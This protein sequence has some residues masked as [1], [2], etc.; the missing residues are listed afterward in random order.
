ML[1]EFKDGI[2]AYL[3]AAGIKPKSLADLIAWNQDHSDTVM[4]WFG[5][6]L[7]EMAQAKGSLKDAAYR[8]ARAKAR[9]IAGDDGL[10]ATLDANRVDVLM[11]PSAGPSWLT[12]LLLG[13]HYVGGGGAGMAAV[14]GTPSIT[15]PMGE[16]HGL[17]L[18]LALMGPAYSEAQL[19]GLAYA[20]EQASLAR[21]PPKYFATLPT[22]TAAVKADDA[23]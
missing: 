22:T 4:P 6:E 14:A 8:E 9:K 1:Y 19:I 10:F 23:H 12:D 2:N 15:V 11:V 13:D 18:G 16:S 5:Q 17:P 20:F 21:T 7:F 3:K